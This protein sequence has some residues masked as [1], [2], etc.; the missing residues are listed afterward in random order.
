MARRRSASQAPGGEGSNMPEAFAVYK[1]SRY[2]AGLCRFGKPGY[3]AG[4]G[5]GRSHRGIANLC[6]IKAWRHPSAR[7]ASS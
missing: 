1:R 5:R 2:K 4:Q 3:L 7:F 6:P